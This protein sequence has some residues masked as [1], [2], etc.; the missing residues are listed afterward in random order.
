MTREELLEQWEIFKRANRYSF[1]TQPDEVERYIAGEDIEFKVKRSSSYYFTYPKKITGELKGE[2]AETARRILKVISMVKERLIN[3]YDVK[4]ELPIVSQLGYSLREVAEAAAVEMYRTYFKIVADEIKN[5][6]KYY[7]EEEIEKYV[8]ALKIP[9][10]G[11]TAKSEYSLKIKHVMAILAAELV[12]KD[13]EK[14]G[15]YVEHIIHY[16]E[17]G[18]SDIAAFILL[19]LF[20]ISPEVQKSVLKLMEEEILFVKYVFIER[21]G[22]RIEALDK[23]CKEYGI[24]PTVTP[25]FV[26]YILMEQYNNR[27]N[28]TNAKYFKNLYKEDRETFLKVYNKIEKKKLVLKMYL[29]SVLLANNE[30]KEELKEAEKDII[31]LLVKGSKAE[32]EVLEEKINACLSGKNLENEIA[33]IIKSNTV[34]KNI[35]ETIEALGC[36]YD[37]SEKIKVIINAQFKEGALKQYGMV[38]QYNSFLKGRREWLESPTAESARLLVENGYPVKNIFE[39]YAEVG[40]GSYWEDY[41]TLEDTVEILKGNEETAIELLVEITKKPTIEVIPKCTRLMELLYEKYDMPDKS[42]EFLIKELADNKSKT[43]QKKA[44]EIITNNPERSRKLVEEELPKIKGNL[45]QMFNRVIKFWDNEFLFKDGFKFTKEEAEEFCK[46]NYVKENEKLISWIPEN[47][48]EGVKYAEKSGTA[49]KDMIK[50]LLLEYMSLTSP[51]RVKSVDKIVEVLDLRSLQNV[52]ENIYQL[53]LGNGADT[54]QKA[55]MLPYCIYGAD[56]QLIELRKQL[57]KWAEVSR[58]A[59][60]AYVVPAIALNGGSVALMMVDSISGKFPNNQVKK[61]AKSAFALVSAALGISEDALSDK[62]IPDFGFSREGKKVLDFGSRTFTITMTPD[63]SLSIYDDEKEKVVKSLPKPAAAD[64]P[65]KAESAKKELAELKKQLKTTVQTQ[66]LRLKK[67]LMNGR[68]WKAEDWNRLFVENPVMHKFAIGLIWGVY[69]DGKLLE[70]FRYMED[71][72]FNTA[73]EEEYTLPEK[74]QITLVHPVELTE[75]ELK[76]WKEQLDDY[77]ITQ[78]FDQLGS[79]PLTLK[80]EDMNG[81]AV[82]RYEGKETT[83]GK[84]TGAIKKYDFVRGPIWDAGGFSCYFMVDKFLGLYVHIGGEMMYVGQAH[85][86]SV[87]LEKVTFCRL[88]ENGEP[89]E[90][91]KDNMILDPAEL[92]KRFVSSVLAIMEELV[93]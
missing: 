72:S 91:I 22:S 21:F 10:D 79:E 8:S 82:V 83:A 65:V 57:E 39:I 30:G 54:K 90:E 44:E 50:F 67:V 3:A 38:M 93:I 6:F 46:N 1:P 56:S 86:E 14:Y 73:D 29:L 59:L 16:A 26:F 85:D 49:S 25:E 62:I 70:S 74:A 87:T 19:K 43:I 80:A 61:A 77:E 40:G 23:F 58:G 20:D 24:S 27:D 18:N 52:L 7:S 4:T 11:V 53:W 47:L 68:C 76:Q 63:F 12:L 5:L 81:K 41:I 84:L 51:Y 42:W 60:A 89:D 55:V 32:P 45:L 92:P 17:I 71:G 15:E 9:E 28:K 75:E 66:I 69:E 31:Q 35:T 78:P 37:Y 88:P 13:R 2:E 36:L 34:K 33:E 64:D 48:F